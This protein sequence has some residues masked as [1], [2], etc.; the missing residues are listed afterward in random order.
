MQQFRLGL[1]EID[2]VLFWFSTGHQHSLTQVSQRRIEFIEGA[3]TLKV[4][5][6]AQVKLCTE[7]STQQQSA[8]PH[9]S[10]DS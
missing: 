7:A 1:S 3:S 4:A 8:R 2:V 10:Y 5:S 9:I 6:W